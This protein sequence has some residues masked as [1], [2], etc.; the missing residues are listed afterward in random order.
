MDR[1]VSISIV[2]DHSHQLFMQVEWPYTAY[3]CIKFSVPICV[4]VCHARG[5]AHALQEAPLSAL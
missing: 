5:I 3:Q 2:C 1:L 4:S